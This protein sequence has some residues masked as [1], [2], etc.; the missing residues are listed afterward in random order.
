[1]T[2]VLHIISKCIFF[3]RPKKSLQSVPKGAVDDKMK[4]GPG[5]GL[6]PRRHQAIIWVSGDTGQWCIY[7]SLGLIELIISPY[8]ENIMMWRKTVLFEHMRDTFTPI[9]ESGQFR[10]VRSGRVEGGLTMICKIPNGDFTKYGQPVPRPDP[11]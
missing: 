6:A 2:T 5:N 9:A 8:W 3:K 11:T 1:M 4:I 10:P 7:A